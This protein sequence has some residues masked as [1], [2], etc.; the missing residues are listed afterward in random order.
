M[1][2]MARYSYKLDGPKARLHCN[3]EI[4]VTTRHH[5]VIFT[6]VKERQSPAF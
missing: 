3:Y 5:M 6:V 4:Y 2:I 1:A